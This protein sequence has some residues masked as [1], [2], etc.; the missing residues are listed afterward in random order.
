MFL[1]VAT[2]VLLAV[3]LIQDHPRAAGFGM[4]DPRGAA[5]VEYF[6]AGAGDDR[7]RGMRTIRTESAI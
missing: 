4:S 2:G 7:N 1:R 5:G 6:V 3:W